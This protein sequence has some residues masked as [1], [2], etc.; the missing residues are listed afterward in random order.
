MF[1][2]ARNPFFGVGMDNY[3][4]FSDREQGTHN[5][6]TQ[7]SAEIGIRGYALVYVSISPRHV[8]AS[9]EDAD[10]KECG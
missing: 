7:V 6:Y 3:V 4:L 5:S 2:S 9:G 1:L 8:E 10:S